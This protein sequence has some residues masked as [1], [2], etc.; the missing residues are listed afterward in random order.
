VWSD[1]QSGAMTQAEVVHAIDD[2]RV[3][4]VDT[5]NPAKD[6]QLKTGQRI[7]RSSGVSCSA[8]VGRE[9]VANSG[10]AR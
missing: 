2:L 6:G 7:G 10:I 9:Q 8:S 1:E 4:S 3:A 5:S